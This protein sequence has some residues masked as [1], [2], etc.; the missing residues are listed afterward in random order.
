MGYHAP[1]LDVILHLAT[2]LVAGVL[3]TI[4]ALSYKR[5]DNEK[6]R[7]IASAFGVFSLKEFVVLLNNGMMYA[8]VFSELNHVLNLMILLLFYRGTTR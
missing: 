8:S 3:F 1:I 5:K 7:Y 4:S 2:F 6:F